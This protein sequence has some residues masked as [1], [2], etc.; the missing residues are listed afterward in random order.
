MICLVYLWL[1][2]ARSLADKQTDDARNS[3]FFRFYYGHSEDGTLKEIMLIDPDSYKSGSTIELTLP[4]SKDNEDSYNWHSNIFDGTVCIPCFPGHTK[5][6]PAVLASIDEQMIS[7]LRVV[8]AHSEIDENQSRELLEL[9]GTRKYEVILTATVSKQTGPQNI[10]RAIRHSRGKYI[11]VFDADDVMFSERLFFLSF[12]FE[13]VPEC[14]IVVHAFGPPIVQFSKSPSKLHIE[15]ASVVAEL[16]RQNPETFFLGLWN[17]AHGPATSKIEL[18]QRLKYSFEPEYS[19]GFDV[20]FLHD[21]I[22]M[23]VNVCL[24][25]LPLMF[26][27][28][29]ED[30]LTGRQWWRPGV[31]QAID[32]LSS[33]DSV[34]PMNKS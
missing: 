27:T 7:P 1:S 31:I 13:S 2:C 19:R 6:L 29:Y 10:D 24:L 18:H 8:I 17:G 3:P 4:L 33:G 12:V 34:K 25:T 32:F 11:S 16:A 20:K 22:K 15:P 21:A 23:G 30:V 5:Y 28:P 9:L 26:Y 14:D